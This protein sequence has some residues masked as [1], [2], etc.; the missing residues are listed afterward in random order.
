MEYD[1]DVGNFVNTCRMM[2]MMMMLI[3]S[4]SIVVAR[5]GGENEGWPARLLQPKASQGKDAD[6]KKLKN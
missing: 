4:L 2:L 3:I 1:D 5:R 6:Q